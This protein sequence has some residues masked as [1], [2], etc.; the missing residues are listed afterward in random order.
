MQILNTVYVDDHRARIRI[1]RGNLLIE[2]SNDSARVPIETVENIVLTGRAEITN[3]ALGTLCE[4][5]VRVAALSKSGKTRFTVSGA[6]SGN[7]LLRVGQ[8]EAAR[9]QTRA[10]KIARV[11]VAGKIQNCRR[12]MLRWAN[13][14]GEDRRRFEAAA[15]DLRN[16]LDGLAAAHTGDEIR[17]IE[18]DATRRYFKLMGLQVRQPSTVFSFERR[19]RRPPRDPFNALLSFLYGLV[20][21]DITGSLDAIGLDPQVGFLHQLRPGRPSLALDLIE[22]LRPSF[23]D[24][25][26][27]RLV[28]RVQLGSDDFDEVPGGAVYLSSSGRDIVFREITKF[29]QEETLHPVLDRTVRIGQLPTIQATLMA[30]HLRGDLDVYP[31]YVL[32]G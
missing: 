20:L 15:E 12:M 31:P 9:D 14:A 13:D 19:S 25:L 1:R 23:A 24:R 16:R 21:V 27:M 8:Y 18:G 4:R 5:G 6:T 10:F 22:E 17:G 7:V 2:N 28:N 26:A 32:T 11:V 30:R 3:A 29:K